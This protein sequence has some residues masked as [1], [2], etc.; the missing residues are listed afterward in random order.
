VED[1]AL[2]ALLELGRLLKHAGYRF[3]T[4]TPETHRR[5][6]ERA[7]RDGRELSSSLR[8][9]FG[10]NRPFVRDLLPAAML[11]ALRDA[12]LIGREGRHLCSQVRFASVGYRLFA[13]SAFPTAAN[14]SVFFGPDSYR[15]CAL[16]DRWA[17][18]RAR[19]MVDVG[20]GSG[21]GGICAARHAREVVLADINSRALSFAEV[22]A[23]LDGTAAH[24]VASDVLGAVEGPIDLVIANPPYMRDPAGRAY[25][26]GGGSH[27]EALAVRIAREAL[28]RLEPHGAL[29]LYTGSAVVDGRDTFLDAVAPVLEDAGR[30]FQYEELDP[31]V[32]GEE[33]DQPGYADVE[34][35]AAVGLRVGEDV[36]VSAKRPNAAR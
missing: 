21:V 6:N 13:H 19:R 18:G 15:F 1:A 2:A 5:V 29:I 17:V 23:A 3:T 30:P 26:D 24:V 14:D 22:N 28:A 12:D 4:V 11:D 7:R 34:R 31:D 20:C 9:V 36:L 25:R 32:F 33:L 27:G 35:I 10:W 8:D 16:V